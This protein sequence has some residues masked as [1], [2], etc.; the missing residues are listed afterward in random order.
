MSI[1]KYA[2]KIKE[3]V[4]TKL[5]IEDKL[6]ELDVKRTKECEAKI[7]NGPATILYFEYFNQKYDIARKLGKIEDSMKKDGFEITKYCELHN[8]YIDM[9]RETK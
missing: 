9:Y 6:L 5:L 4:L 2:A 1:E 7:Y 8:R 3:L